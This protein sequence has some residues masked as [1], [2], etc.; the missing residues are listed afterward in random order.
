MV[1]SKSFSFPEMDTT[2]GKFLANVAV[3][4]FATLILNIPL[5]LIEYLEEF[6][7]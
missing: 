3:A 4:F 5:F 6:I 2:Y 1:C 7:K